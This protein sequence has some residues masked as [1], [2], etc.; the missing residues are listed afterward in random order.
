MWKEFKTFAMREMSWIWPWADHRSRVR[1]DRHVARLRCAPA[2][3]RA[4]ARQ[5]ELHNFFAVHNEAA[6]PYATSEAAQKAGAVTINYGRFINSVISFLIVAFAVFM[7]VRS[8][9][10]LVQ[11]EAAPPPKPNTKD[12]PHCLSSIPIKATRCAHWRRISRLDDKSGA[13]APISVP[14]RAWRSS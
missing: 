1:S 4:A 5:R 7:L 9:D 12:C 3:D 11:K 2:A 6:G 8:V 10:R 14:G 13:S